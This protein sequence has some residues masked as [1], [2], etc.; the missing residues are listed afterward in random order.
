MTNMNANQELEQFKKLVTQWVTIHLSVL[1]ANVTIE[2]DINRIK[3]TEQDLGQEALNILHRYQIETAD[4]ESA[5]SDARN[6]AIGENP[7][8][9]LDAVM[10][11]LKQE[12]SRIL[13]TP[14]IEP[15]VENLR[16]Y[17]RTIF[18]N[19]ELASKNQELYEKSLNI[20]LHPTLVNTNPV[21]LQDM[22]RM[23]KEF[24]RCFL[25][26]ERRLNSTEEESNGSSSSYQT[27]DSSSDNEKN[28]DDD[29]NDGKSVSF[30]DSKNQVIPDDDDPQ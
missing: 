5:V 4:L 27:V 10:A 23:F 1:E 24:L 8:L 6:A 12:M 13:N 25:A 14:V 21:Y 3:E 7:A 16:N 29:N 22:K 11:R 18:T 19:P 2:E 17:Y 30:D 28:E 20:I 9:D 26:E 15:L